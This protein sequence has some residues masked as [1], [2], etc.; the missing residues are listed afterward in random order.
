MRYFIVI[1]FLNISAVHATGILPEWKDPEIACVQNND[2]K[3]SLK[4]AEQ[5]HVLTPN[6]LEC[7][8]G[9]LI[10][11]RRSGGVVLFCDISE[12]VLTVDGYSVCTYRGSIRTVRGIDITPQ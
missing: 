3:R 10:V 6:P 9:D 4:D 5:V 7:K 12:K 8:K 2:M 1:S 11:V